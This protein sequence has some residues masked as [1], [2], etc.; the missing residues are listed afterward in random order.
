[1]SN[2]LPQSLIDDYRDFVKDGDFKKAR[3]I[4]RLIKALQ[5]ETYSLPE[6]EDI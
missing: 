2:Q 4:L 5:Y 6:D 1:M 3:K